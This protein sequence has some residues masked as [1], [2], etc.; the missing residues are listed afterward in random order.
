MDLKCG[1]FEDATYNANARVMQG[2]FENVDNTFDVHLPLKR[3]VDAVM[4][5]LI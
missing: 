4:I 1:D 3:S 5:R 2:S